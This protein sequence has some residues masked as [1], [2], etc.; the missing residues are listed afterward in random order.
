MRLV[1]H[2]HLKTWQAQNNIAGEDILQEDNEEVILIQEP[3][4]VPPHILAN[5]SNLLGQANGLENGEE[6]KNPA[7]EEAGEDNEQEVLEPP[8]PRQQMTYQTA[9]SKGDTHL[10]KRLE[11]WSAAYSNK[12]MKEWITQW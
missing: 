3:V 7:E 10:L 9:F 2:T 12:T 5:T 4:Q 8:N 11:D 6:A 1:Y